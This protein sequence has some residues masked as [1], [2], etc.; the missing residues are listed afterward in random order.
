MARKDTIGGN[1]FCQ[2]LFPPMVSFLAICTSQNQW[3]SDDADKISGP[4]NYESVSRYS[5]ARRIA[6]IMIY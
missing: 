4:L 2:K 3:F 5:P 1:N 6:F